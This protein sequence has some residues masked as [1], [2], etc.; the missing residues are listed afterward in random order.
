MDVPQHRKSSTRGSLVHAILSLA[1]LASS[2]VANARPQVLTLEGTKEIAGRKLAWRRC[3]D[4]EQGRFAEFTADRLQGGG[5]VWSGRH[6]WEID[7]SGGVHPLNADFAQQRLR[8]LQRIFGHGTTLVSGASAIDGAEAPIPEI[9]G[10]LPI[11][12]SRDDAGTHVTLPGDLAPETWTLADFREVVPGVAV[13]FMEMAGS[14]AG[15]RVIRVSAAEL[16]SDPADCRT[17]RPDTLN[18]LIFSRTATRAEVP[19]EFDGRVVVRASIN[20][21][22]PLPFIV[23]T[24]GHNILSSAVATSL[25]LT[26]EGHESTGGAGGARVDSSRSMVSSVDIGGATLVNQPFL[27]LPLPYP[28]I[29]RGSEDPIAGILGLQLFERATVTIDYAKR[30]L[31]ID[32]IGSAPDDAPESLPIAFIDDTP[33]VKAALD[34]H[35]GLFF[36]DTGNASTTMLHTPWAQAQLDVDALKQGERGVAMGIGGLIPRWTTQGH[37]L[38]VGDFELAGLPVSYAESTSGAFASR[39]TAGN[40]GTDVLANFAVTFDYQGGRM[41][42]RRTSAYAPRPPLGLGAALA[43]VAP[44]FAA[45]VAVEAGSPAARAGLS[46]G[47]RVRAVNGRSVE[48]LSTMEIADL[49]RNNQQPLQLKIERS[50]IISEAL[51]ER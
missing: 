38:S 13:P 45:V 5:V 9:P 15:T 12:V 2:S 7:E 26:L 21:S 28:A 50:G 23:D 51:L 36:I 44:D 8:S 29:E 1:V 37:T 46:P 42:L 48:G 49:L 4:L 17:E 20:G 47:D 24:G 14:G 39:A 31:V 43:K 18:P 35:A 25:G 10:G 19:I 22:P 41:F 27:V 30:R 3:V 33:L 16:L 34:G 32:P 11:T 6:G 40:I